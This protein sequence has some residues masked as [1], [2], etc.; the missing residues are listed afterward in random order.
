MRAATGDE[1]RFSTLFPFLIESVL[2]GGGDDSRTRLFLLTAGVSSAE[3]RYLP[4]T[5]TRGLGGQ[6]FR[7][8]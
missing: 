3:C 7:T 5:L 4:A 8:G 6:Y 2:K 1:D